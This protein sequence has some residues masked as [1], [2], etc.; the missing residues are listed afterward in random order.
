MVWIAALVAPMAAVAGHVASPQIV[1]SVRPAQVRK[2]QSVQTL[3]AT[4]AVVSISAPQAVAEQAAPAPQAPASE[5]S[6]PLRWGHDELRR[7]VNS[8]SAQERQQ[9]GIVPPQRWTADTPGDGAA[10][11]RLTEQHGSGGTRVTRVQRGGVVYCVEI[12]SLNQPP[13][14]GAAPRVALPRSCS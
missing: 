10:G 7:A 6:Q 8:A 4:A 14:M 3:S 12:P 13:A 1:P 9:G 2:K 11:V 5:P